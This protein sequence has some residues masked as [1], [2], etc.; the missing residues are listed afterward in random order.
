MTS[1]WLER[2]TPEPGDGPTV[3][4]KD[5]FDV[6]GSVTTA[7]CRA[8]ADRGMP[9]LVDAPC[10]EAVRRAGGRLAGKTNM[11][12]LA[13]GTSGINPW[14]GTPAN[15]ADPGRVPGG[16]SSGSAVAVAGGEADIALGSDTGGSV[17][18]P[19]ACCGVVGLKTTHGLVSLQGVWPL[20][21]SYDTVGVL[22]PDV[23]GILAGMGLLG[24]TLAAAGEL[25]QVVGLAGLPPE[26]ADR[27]DPV[28]AAAVS[29]AL[30]AAE[31]R[32]EVAPVPGWREAWRA[33][34]VLIC[35]EAWEC[36]RHL[37]EGGH[38]SGVSDE[39][40]DRLLVGAGYGEAELARAAGVRAAWCTELAGAVQRCGVLALP[41]LAVRPPLLG[42]FRTGFNMLTA[43]VN[44]AGLPA[45]SLPVPLTERGRPAA[46][47]QLVGPAGSEAM[48]CRLAG[49][50]E[51]AC[52]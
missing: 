15:P 14:F 41:T 24:E 21:P 29:S 44:F 42:A 52:G 47:L 18:I 20:A 2:W 3:A 35:A 33:H 26:I 28:I 9:A 1:T 36:D 11:H 4:V 48:L 5:L 23:A 12:E 50:V 13:F 49:A 16:S 37:L 51:A 46:S 10:I 22:A 25:P 31:L 7:G 40:R 32:V 34:Q 45:I 6:A 17:R 39:V 19:A 30:V 43:P 27:V 38:E 8:L